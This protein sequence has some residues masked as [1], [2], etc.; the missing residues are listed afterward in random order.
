MKCINDY[1]LVTKIGKGS[2]GEVWKAININKK[3]YVAIKIEKKNT[4][5]I[6]KHETVILRQMQHLTNVVDIKYFGESSTFNYLILELLTVP[7]DTYFNNMILHG[8]DKNILIIKIGIQIFNCLNNIHREGILHRDVKPA[9]FLMDDKN[10]VKIIDFGLSRQYIDKNGNHKVNTKKNKITGTLRF[11]SKFIH[12]GNEPSR[13][14][15][16]ISMVYIIIYLLNGSL[17]W[18]GLTVSN[19]CEKENVIYKIK[20]NYLNFQNLKINTTIPIKLTELLEYLEN[21]SY[22]ETPNY[23]YI[24]F[25]IKTL[26]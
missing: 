11:I 4:K 12:E 5:N 14:D 19:R 1:K 3:K 10:H 6:L 7:V 16:L 18:Q 23:D 8:Y 13:R 25:L 20:N 21:L 22:N 17:P 2:Y 15:D 9:N 24:L 26:L